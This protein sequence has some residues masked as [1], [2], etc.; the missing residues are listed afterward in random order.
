MLSENEQAGKQCMWFLLSNMGTWSYTSVST[1]GHV[2]DMDLE[3]Q[4][5]L[6]RTQTKL[7][8]GNLSGMGWWWLKLINF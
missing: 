1:Y 3:S 8:P 7:L 6:E 4:E 5:N 2:C